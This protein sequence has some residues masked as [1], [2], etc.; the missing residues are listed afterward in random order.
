MGIPVE[1]QVR[2]RWQH[3]WAELFEKLADRVG[4]GIRY[5][6]APRRLFSQAEFD[7]LPWEVR[8]AVAIF[9]RN[10]ELTVDLAMT[11]ADLVSAVEQGQVE[12]PDDPELAGFRSQAEQALNNLRETL[13]DFEKWDGQITTAQAQARSR[14]DSTGH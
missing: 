12:D 6:D 13:L 8:D 14:L 3:E 7:E 4:R 10:R 1:I 5:G 9:N 11:V 2:T